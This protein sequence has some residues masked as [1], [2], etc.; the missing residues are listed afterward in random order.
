[1]NLGTS[2]FLVWLL[3]AWIKPVQHQPATPVYVEKQAAALQ[4]A[5][6]GDLEMLADAPRYSI[7]ASVNPADGLVT[8]HMSLQYTNTSQATLSELV[9]RLYPNAE[10][11]Y[12]GGSLTVDSVTQAGTPRESVLSE[13]QTTL[14]VPLEHRLE[15]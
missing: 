9:F 11:I 3:G 8:G 13:D 10:T 6:R 2:L 12:G 4:P 15:P 5:F 7:E 1:M 14:R